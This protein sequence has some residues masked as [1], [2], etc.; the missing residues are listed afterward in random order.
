MNTYLTQFSSLHTNK[1]HGVQAPHKAVLLLSN[2][3]MVESGSIK[4]PEIELTDVLEQ[5]FQHNWERYVG[6]SPIFSASMGMPFFHMRYEPFWS[7]VPLQGGE[8][9]IRELSKGSPYALSTLRSEIRCAVIDDALFKF[10][11]D[12]DFRAKARVELIS[13]YLHVG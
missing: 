4:S 2:I 5:R 6:R 10:M 13:G 11:Q 1:Q 12:N 8:S 7:L 3:D 9:H